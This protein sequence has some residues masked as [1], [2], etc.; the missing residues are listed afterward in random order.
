MINKNGVEID[1]TS[2][3]LGFAL[4]EMGAPHISFDTTITASMMTDVIDSSGPSAWPMAAYSYLTGSTMD[5]HDAEELAVLF[6]E[7]GFHRVAYKKF[8]M[9]TIAIHWGTK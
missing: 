2:L 1:A 8:M 7:A 6:R 5:F 4:S 3:S 9:G